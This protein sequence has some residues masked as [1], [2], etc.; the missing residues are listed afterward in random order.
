LNFAVDDLDQH[1]T[2]VS[3]RGLTPGAIQTASKGVWPLAPSCAPTSGS[4]AH[5]AGHAGAK[6]ARALGTPVDCCPLRWG[7]ER[8]AAA[9]AALLAAQE[10]TTVVRPALATSDDAIRSRTG[11]GWEE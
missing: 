11:R 7:H 4:G 3:Q 1:V 9:R 10:P 5:A 6:G 2:E 8:Y